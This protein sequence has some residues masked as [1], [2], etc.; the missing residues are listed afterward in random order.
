[1]KTHTLQYCSINGYNCNDGCKEFK[2][3]L[4][5]SI[6]VNDLNG[7][8]LHIME[9]YFVPGNYFT[10]DDYDCNEKSIEIKFCPFCGAELQ[11]GEDIPVTEDDY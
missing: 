5:S 7:I 8:T 1:M 11:L 2:N 6:I 10:P 3:L 4:N 9:Y